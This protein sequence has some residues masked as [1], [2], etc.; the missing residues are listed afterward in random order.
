MFLAPQGACIT[1]SG[2]Y[3]ND[4][5]ASQ[6]YSRGAAKTRALVMQSHHQSGR[7]ATRGVQM[8]KSNGDVKVNTRKQTEYKNLRTQT[9]AISSATVDG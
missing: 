9:P 2:F 7:S 4:A 3:I 6:Y 5:T 1:S 8:I